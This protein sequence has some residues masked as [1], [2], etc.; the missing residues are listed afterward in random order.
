MPDEDHSETGKSKREDGRFSEVVELGC[1]CWRNK[2]EKE[3][4]VALLLEED[5]VSCQIKKKDVQVHQRMLIF[6]N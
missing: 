4:E 5:D 3:L 2:T 6:R 1:S